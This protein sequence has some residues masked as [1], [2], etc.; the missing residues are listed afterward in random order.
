MSSI[1]ESEIQRLTQLLKQAEEQAKQA[2]EQAKQDRASR[3]EAEQQAKQAEEEAKQ[4]NLKIRRTSFKTYLH[5]CHTLLSKPLRYSM[6]RVSAHK[7]RLRARRTNRVPPKLNL[8][9]TSRRNT[10]IFLRRSQNISGRMPKTSVLD[11]ISKN[12]AGNSVVAHSQA[13]K[14]WRHTSV[15]QLKDPSRI[16]YLSFRKVM[17]RGK[18]WD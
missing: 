9:P 3:R 6:I 15:W 2:E 13:K 8:G 10:V 5:S 17:L 14:T 18:N 12:S 4:A 16:S 1:P 11:N 7:A